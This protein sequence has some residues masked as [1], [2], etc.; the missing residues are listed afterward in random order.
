MLRVL[1]RPSG[2]NMNK[3]LFKLGFLFAV[4]LALFVAAENGVFDN[5]NHF[6]NNVTNVTN[7][8]T[9]SLN[10]S[11][12]IY[13]GGT[14]LSSK[15]GLL[16]G[17]NSI[18]SSVVSLVSSNTT[19]NGRVTEVNSTAN[20]KAATY[21]VHDATNITT[22]TLSAARLVGNYSINISGK[23]ATCGTADLVTN[24]I[25]TTST[26]TGG[27]LSGTGLAPQ[28]TD[29]SHAHA[30]NNI[31]AG[32][33]GTGNFVFGTNVTMEHLILEGNTSRIAAE[34][35]VSC[36]LIYGATSTLAVC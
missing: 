11:G 34:A 23:S 9:V 7:V 22:G 21:H 27:D 17:M 28:V 14:S 12:T 4:L 36:T 24:G 5:E 13:E 20:G 16:A 35:N 3:N 31:T 8:Q 1:K 33:F 26:W 15:Y 10:A 32:T 6:G 30:A 2:V 25:Y 18:N 29:S 19:T